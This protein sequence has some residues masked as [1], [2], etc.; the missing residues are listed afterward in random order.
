M[1]LTIERN[2][3]L[4]NPETRPFLA[5][6]FYPEQNGKFPLVIFV[7]GYKGYKDW[8]AWDLMGEKIASA[9]NFFVKFNFSH[10]GTTTDNPKEFADLKAFG[11]NN[12]TKELSDYT[13]VI[14]HFINHKKVDAENVLIIGHS[15]GGGITIIQG[16]EDARVKLVSVLAGVSHFG[17]R[18]PQQDR[19]DTW[20]KSGVFY[21]E[22]ARTKQQ[23]PHYFQFYED[24]KANEQRFNI[25]FAAQH[26]E[27]PLL[28]IQGTEDEAVKSHE[29][30]LLSQWAKEGEIHYLEGAT[31]TFG[32]KEPWTEEALPPDLEKATE[33]I[34]DFI[35]RNL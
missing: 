3:I 11:H 7:H 6:A 22:N 20:Q 23:M 31:H 2:L 8:G 29:A 14:D 24:Y 28:I 13:I 1:K 4:E 26:L 5:D 35:N 9:G 34:I 21:S 15:R 12:F 27:K 33:L 32:A 30:D 10:N 25:Q 17:Y 18:F 16:F 19:F